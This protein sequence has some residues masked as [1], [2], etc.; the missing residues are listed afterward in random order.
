MSSSDNLIA[1]LSKIISADRIV[2]S[3]EE[4]TFYS[5]DI[6]ARG[7]T[8]ELVVRVLSVEELS[9]T[10]R[11]CTSNGRIVI[12]RGGGFSYTSGY[13]PV[14]SQSVIIDLRGLNRIVEI[15]TDDMYV[16][17]EVGCTWEQLYEA[18]KAKGVRT[19]YFGPMSGYSATVGGALSQGSFFLGSSQYGAVAESVLALEVVI[20]DGTIVK[21]GSWGSTIG[22]GPFMR[23]YGPDLTGLFLSD[24]G[25][26]G[27]KA[28]AV[29]KLIPFPAHQ[30]FGS[31]VFDNEHNAI[32]AL[33]EIGRS[34]LAAECYCWDPYFVKMMSASNDS[35]AE[36]LKFLAGVAKDGSSR[37][38][39]LINAAR[40]AMAGKRVFSGELFILNLVIDDASEVGAT[41]RLELL[42]AMVDRHDGR[43]ITASAPMALRGTPFTN[44]NVPRR[45]EKLRS[46][47]TNSLSPHS[48]IIEVSDAVRSFLSK[49][50]EKLTSNQI[51]CG[52]IYFAVGAQAVCCEPLLYWEDEEHY[53]HNRLEDKSNLSELARYTERP[54]AT[55][56]ALAIRKDLSATFKALGCVHVQI[57][58]AYPY[59]QTR[60][61][62][63]LALIKS[64]K[65]N[66]DPENLMNRGS[67]GFDSTK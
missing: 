26:L 57:G 51:N 59:L 8:A 41:A 28:T 21:T 16:T 11:I 60:E 22:T 63:T 17:V 39:G 40:V 20:A 65:R 44:F 37:V 50:K 13:V 33:S 34:G 10:I 52:V 46:L 2:S 58:K 29:F 19:P 47:P 42:R 5:T 15:N 35:L 7:E 25:A 36:D 53:H 4:R 9:Q 38:K 56:V 67:L 62:A 27:F 43:E 66:L 3:L 61:P 24:T 45:R 18:L 12:P 31:F 32:K 6:S 64:I 48:K 55:K 14:S 1:L 54:E 23:N 30:Q 49:N